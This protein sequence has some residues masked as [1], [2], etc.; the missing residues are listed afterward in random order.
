MKLFPL[1]NSLLSPI[2]QR[3][4]NTIVLYL[5]TCMK[6][7]FAH[8]SE[9]LKEPISHELRGQLRESFR[10]LQPDLLLQ[11]LFKQVLLKST[12]D[13]GLRA[14]HVPLT[15]QNNQMDA[16]ADRPYGHD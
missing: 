15:E 4:L 13:C 16:I 11:L 2:Y 5:N 9:R 10:R 7:P 14:Q 1:S 8:I 3:V 12:P 6:D